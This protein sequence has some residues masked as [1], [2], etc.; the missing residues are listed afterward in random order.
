[1]NRSTSRFIGVLA[2]FA[3]SLSLSFLAEA[4]SAKGQIPKAAPLSKSYT[5]YDGDKKRT[6]YLN[7]NLL[8]EF[9]V[10][11]EAQSKV[12][13]TVPAKA[14]SRKGA[15]RI[16]RVD[17]GAD[18]AIASVRAATPRA[19]V[20]P[21]FHDDASDTGRMRALT[22]NIIVYLDPRWNET[23]VNQFL[24]RNDLVLVKKLEI[25]ANIFV[26]K[27]GSGLAALEKANA[28]YE[29][30]GVVAA[31]PEWWQEIAPR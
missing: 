8:A 31:F 30:G 24:A 27:D 15:V 14:V 2:V 1:M 5:W 6:I 23:A 10:T 13:Q 16:W 19:D 12:L 17:D 26:V 3:I 4:A 25:G 18:H 21:V 29:S 9:H 11:D 7:P 22:G 20:S 28:L